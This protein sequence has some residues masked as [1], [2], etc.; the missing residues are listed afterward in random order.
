MDSKLLTVILLAFLSPTVI[1]Q[2]SNASQMATAD[3]LLDRKVPN[4]CV[5]EERRG[6]LECV[7]VRDARID[8]VLIGSLTLQEPPIPFGFVGIPTEDPDAGIDLSPPGSSVRNLLDA[9]VAADLRY[10]WE[11]RDGVVNLVPTAGIPPLLEVRLTAF[12]EDGTMS[13]LLWALEN[14]PEV[15]KR[16]A[17]LGFAGPTQPIFQFGAV[18][19]RKFG[20]H[21]R[22]C[23]VRDVLN[24]VVRR[25][26]QFWK[27]R[28]PKFGG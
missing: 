28:E 22:D 16:A 9:L 12:D 5:G 1:G 11:V 6:T 13:H 20:I 14:A 3:D 8:E 4:Y 10:R 2:T 17:E 21:C 23:S 7:P 19:R 18:D 27:Y 15:R 26:G 24:E 25:N